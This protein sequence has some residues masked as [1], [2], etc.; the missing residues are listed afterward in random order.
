MSKTTCKILIADDEYWVRENLKKL[1]NW[2]ELS[3]ELIEPA[4]DGEDALNKIAEQLPDILITDVNM[5]FINGTELIRRAK[6][7]QP[8]LQA[9]VVSGYSDYAYMRE[10]LLNGAIDYLLKPITKGALLDVLDKALSILGFNR[11]KERE[12]TMLREKLLMASSVLRDGEMSELIAKDT[13]DDVS[14]TKFMELE[15]K[16][17]VF[18]L[19]LIRLSDLHTAMEKYLNDFP[20]LCFDVKNILVQKSLTGHGVAFHNNYVRNEFIF[21]TDL[22]EKGI[23]VFCGKLPESIQIATGSKVDIA[24]SN[25]YYAFERLRHA[26]HESHSALLVRKLGGD[27]VTVRVQDVQG[28]P[29]QRRVSPEQEK[30]LLYAIQSR[31]R[32]LAHDI[33]F[34]K[35]GLRKSEAEGWL[36]IEVKQTTN[37]ISGMIIHGADSSASPHS[38]LALENLTYLLG[39]ALEMQ[40]VSE[41][42]SVLEQ[43]LDESMGEPVSNTSNESMKKT[44]LQVQKY[45]EEKYFEDI[46]LTSLSKQ[47]FVDRNYLSKVFKQVTGYNLMLAIAKK[48]IEK[49]VEF[50]KQSGLNLTEVS[51]LVGYED[52]TYF[53]RVFHKIMGVSPSEYK[54]NIL[55]GETD[56]NL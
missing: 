22:D 43:M 52:Y 37:Q 45:V 56:E 55:K 36:F 33:I 9:I 21:L 35:I 25:H 39:I 4:V 30:R 13:L 53:S 14:S 18:T 6:E 7:L 27:S 24:I 12:Q 3:I 19:I 47:F 51:Y 32:H 1:L 48:R 26:Y 31:N 29:V 11:A 50:I 49:A 40:N 41:V 42:Y 15:L 28:L 20:C 16:I 2:D 54:A 5:P 46:S 23:E 17:V 8:K 44:V 10:A 34:N 38:I